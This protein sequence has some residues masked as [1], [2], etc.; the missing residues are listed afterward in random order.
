MVRRGISPM[1]YTESTVEKEKSATVLPEVSLADTPSGSCK[2]ERRLGR[3]VATIGR[4]RRFWVVERKSCRLGR[5]SVYVLFL[6]LSE[7]SPLARPPIHLNVKIGGFLPVRFAASV[8]DKLLL[9]LGGQ[10]GAISFREAKI[11]RGGQD[12]RVARDLLARNLCRP[13]S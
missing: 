7:C 12:R 9:A 11:E 13:P 5:N 3:P 10:V 4:E 2:S 6:P 8:L 1:Q